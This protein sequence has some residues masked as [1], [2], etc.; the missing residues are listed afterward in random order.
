MPIRE[1]FFSAILATSLVAPAWAMP[2]DYQPQDGTYYKLST[3]F[4]GTDMSLDVVN[5]GP[6]DNKIHLAKDGN[7]SGQYWHIVPVPGSDSYMLTTQFRG[8]D[9]C[10]D[11]NLP[12]MQ[13]HLNPCG[14]FTGQR[15]HITSSFAGPQFR[16]LT[17]ETQGSRICM[18]VNPPDNAAQ[19]RPCGRFTG[20]AWMFTDTGQSTQ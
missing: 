6:D 8:N 3:L 15:W 20:Q 12:S 18:D 19:M 14:N 7:Y 11:I 17:N 1:L 16:R 10:L 2:T 13:P 5:G 4:R 9:M